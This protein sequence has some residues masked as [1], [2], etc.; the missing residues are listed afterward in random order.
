M[1]Q[2]PQIQ[3]N[4]GTISVERPKIS[5]SKNF[6]TLGLIKYLLALLKS[7]YMVLSEQEVLIRREALHRTDAPRH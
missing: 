2:N 6:A 1:N 5:A 3:R 7:E 4:S